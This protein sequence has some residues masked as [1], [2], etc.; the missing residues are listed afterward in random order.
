MRLLHAGLRH[1]SGDDAH[2]RARAP[3]RAGIV[4]AHW[5]ATSAV[6]PA[7]ARSWTPRAPLW[8]LPKVP[9][10]RSILQHRCTLNSARCGTDDETLACEGVGRRFMAPRSL[11]ELTDILAREPMA[12]ILG[13]GTDIGLWVTKQHRDLPLVVSHGIC[14]RPSPHRDDRHPC[15]NRW[16]RS[17]MQMPWMA[18]AALHPAIAGLIRRIG[19]R[20][21]RERGTIGGNV[22][23]A[24]PDR[25]HA[26]ACCWRWTPS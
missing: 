9:N 10:V 1:V 5:P 2:G 24:S 26:A 19:S 7:T 13:G 3:D 11:T 25:R 12:L 16:V 4:D 21:I 18:L 6:A 20:Q 8:R 17:P 23:N 15:H 22:A 14:A